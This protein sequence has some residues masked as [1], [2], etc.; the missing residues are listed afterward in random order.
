MKLFLLGATG[1]SGR[2][3]FRFAL[4]RGHEVTAFV[5]DQNKLLNIVGRGA[6]Q[7]VRVI[8]GNI[9]KPTEL[10]AA[11]AG[12]D[13][14][15]NAAGHVTEGARFTQLVQNVIQQASKSLGAGGRLWQFGGAAVLDIP[16]TNMMAVDLPR[17]PKV[18]E[19]HRANLN[20]LKKSSLDW[21]MLC[22]GPMIDSANGE[23]TKGL[24]L[25]AD[26][27]PVERP[28]YTYF[29]PRIA[30][31]LAFKQKVPEL[32]ISYEDAADVILSNLDH[33]GRFS[34]KRVGVALPVG[35]RNFKADVPGR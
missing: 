4:E 22:P 13:V 26:Q 18:Y 25:S 17:V 14:V 21:S 10:A 6:S 8:N 28:S 29:L 11:M 3:I 35:M 30:L 34:R 20:A 32:T 24:R 33:N 15:I 19:A 12:H 27:W 5:R 1:N 23:P 7:G 9:D 2:R 31:A 16:G